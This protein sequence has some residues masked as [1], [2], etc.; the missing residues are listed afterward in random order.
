MNGH[1]SFT[2]SR[3]P[4]ITRSSKPPQKLQQ[5]LSPSGSRH[6]A[7]TVMHN[8]MPATIQIRTHVFVSRTLYIDTRLAG[9]CILLLSSLLFVI[10]KL[11]DYS[12]DTP[13][14]N[15]SLFSFNSRFL[16]QPFILELLLL[17]AASLIYIVWSHT[18]SSSLPATSSSPP[19]APSVPLHPHVVQRPPD[20]REG[21]R[22]ATS[23]M[24][25]NK[26]FGFIWMSV[27]KNYRCE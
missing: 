15:V 2:R 5:T 20:S 16:I 21:R 6:R 23:P 8:F 3:S 27:P 25:M 19:D 13:Q 9:E 12:P 26:N 11:S 14:P 24:V 10:S 4:A 17:V 22:H 7:S 1:R 18:S